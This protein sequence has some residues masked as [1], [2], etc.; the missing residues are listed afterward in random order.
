EGSINSMLVTNIMLPIKLYELANAHGVE[1]F[2]N[3]DTFF[4]QSEIK[5]NYLSEYSMSKKHAL[6]WL[7]TRQDRCKLVNMK[8]FHIYGPGDSPLKFVTEI[9]N[10]LQDN[11]ESINLTRGEQKRDFV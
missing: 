8:L 2:I 7:Y 4:N 6:E 11:V 9:S 3:T 5:Y 10:K 1:V